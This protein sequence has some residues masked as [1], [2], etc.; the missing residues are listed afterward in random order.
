METL[1]CYREGYLPHWEGPGFWINKGTSADSEII[2]SDIQYPERIDFLPPSDAR[3][4]CPLMI[5]F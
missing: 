5:S 2:I 1:W 3:F 4:K